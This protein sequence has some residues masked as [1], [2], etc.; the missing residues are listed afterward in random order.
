MCLRLLS[1][2]FP[3]PPLLLQ[4]LIFCC[5][6]DF[7]LNPFFRSLASPETLFKNRPSGGVPSE[8]LDTGSMIEL[9]VAHH[10]LSSYF[11]SSLSVAHAAGLLSSVWLNFTAAVVLGV[12]PWDWH[13][14]YTWVSHY[15][16]T[17][18]SS[19]SWALSVESSPATQHL[20]PMT[21]PHL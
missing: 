20:A 7:A 14:Q 11:C 2:N 12:I 3:N 1:W 18:T 9:C 17:F 21:P 13:L 4:A 15:N 5:S 10:Q 19:L 8:H 6:L 16:Y